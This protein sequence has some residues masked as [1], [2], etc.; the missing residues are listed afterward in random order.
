[1]CMRWLTAN[2]GANFADPPYP[3][4]RFITHY[5]G[6]VVA[7]LDSPDKQHMRCRFRLVVP[8]RGMAGGGEGECQLSEGGTVRAQFAGK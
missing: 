5:T 3:T 1:M 6:R 4:T 2:S 7:I 8:A